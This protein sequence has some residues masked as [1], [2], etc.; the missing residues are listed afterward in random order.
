MGREDLDAVKQEAASA[1]HVDV[2]TKKTHRVPVLGMLRERRELRAHEVPRFFVLGRGQRHRP[3]PRSVLVT[4]AAG[5]GIDPRG[6][7]PETMF[8]VA[9]EDALIPGGEER[10]TPQ[11]LGRCA[12]R[13]PEVAAERGREGDV[14]AIVEGGDDHGLHEGHGVEEMRMHGGELDPGTSV[15]CCTSRKRSLS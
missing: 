13:G 4:I 2:R 5:L 6:R 12:A 11:C 14:R 8:D 3:I 15:R 7:L 9:V 10:V 1:R